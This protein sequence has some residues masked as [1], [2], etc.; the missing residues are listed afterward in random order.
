MRPVRSRGD[1]LLGR[2]QA[3]L[4]RLVDEQAPHLLERD[5]ADELLDVDP[6]VAE[7]AAVAV[8]LGDLRLEGDDALEARLEVGH[9]APLRS[10]RLD[11]DGT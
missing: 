4:G 2:R 10:G 7:R 5:R 8:G 6:A 3:G 1:V 9:R 11:A